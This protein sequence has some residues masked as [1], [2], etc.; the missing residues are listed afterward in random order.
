MARPRSFRDAL[1]GEQVALI[2]EAKRASPSRGVLRDPYDPVQLAREYEVGGA[3]AL[4]VL[5]EP[6]FFGGRPEHLQAVAQASGLPVLRKDF[7][8][9]PYQCWEAKA[10]GAAAVLLI[11]AALGEDELRSLIALARELALSPLVEVHSPA[12]AKRALDA[13]ADVVG[14]NNRDLNTFRTDLKTTLEVGRALPPSCLLISESG[15][16]SA[17]DVRRVAAAGASAVLV[18]EALVTATQPGA[19]ARELVG[20]ARQTERGNECGSDT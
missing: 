3:Q 5:T 4:S 10:W 12:E 6:E 17:A 16:H 9:D 11:A 15:I 1:R 13:G 19:K 20:I 18:G 2:A 8:V 7:V 14:V